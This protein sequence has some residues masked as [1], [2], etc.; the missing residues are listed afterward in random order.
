MTHQEFATICHPVIVI[1]RW[2]W[3]SS[4][5]DVDR[6]GWTMAEYNIKKIMVELESVH[7]IGCNCFWL[8][9]INDPSCDWA[10]MTLRSI[11]KRLRKEVWAH[12]VFCAAYSLPVYANKRI[13]S[14]LRLVQSK[15][16]LTGVDLHLPTSPTFNCVPI[17]TM[18][19]LEM[20]RSAVRDSP[21]YHTA[22]QPEV[23]VLY[24]QMKWYNHFI[25]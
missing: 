2:C 23:M 16:S 19:Y 22:R 9:T 12:T 5:D 24:Y 6:D 21:D 25:W 3:Q 14:C 7:Q 20:T 10:P 8:V 1:I 11:D 13:C 15:I 17:A 4:F 18:T